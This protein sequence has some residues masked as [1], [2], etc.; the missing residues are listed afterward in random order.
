M[1]RKRMAAA[2]LL[3]LLFGLFIQAACVPAEALEKDPDDTFISLGADLT[4]AEKNIVLG[5]FGIEEADLGAYNVTTVTNQ[6]E[7][8][9]L[10]PYLDRGTIGDRALSSVMVTIREKGYGIHVT[11]H[12]ISYCTVGMYQSA[13]ATAGIRD[14][15]IMVAAPFS[16]SGTAALIGAIHS[17]EGLTG[18][19]MDSGQI[20]AASRELAVSSGLGMVLEDPDRAEQLI[21]MIKNEV[22]ANDYS[23]EEMGSIIEKTAYEIQISLTEEDRQKIL[24]LMDEMKGLDLNIDD[25]KGQVSAV[26][27]K[28]Q[29]VDLSVEKEQA[30]GFLDRLW[31]RLEH[32]VM[33]LF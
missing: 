10:D 5:I 17:Y 19:V 27:S 4:G 13:L 31:E 26:Y 21:G 6:E 12:N 8:Q 1:G 22:I 25:L 24:D 11:T 20:D 33:A 2:F 9:Y 23:R 28:L 15:D 7:H 3:M 18:Q 16:I 32:L 30:K 29:D 14:A